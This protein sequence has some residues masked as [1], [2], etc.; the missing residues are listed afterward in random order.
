MISEVCITGF[1][2]FRSLNSKNINQVFYLKILEMNDSLNIHTEKKI[3]TIP[4]QIRKTEKKLVVADNSNEL[5]AEG[6]DEVYKYVRSIGVSINSKLIVLPSFHHYYYDSDELKKVKSVVVLKKLN[7]I[8]EIENFLD[9][10]LD[11]LPD[12]CNFIGSFINNNKVERYALRQGKTRSEKI[13]NSDRIELDIVSR[14]PFLNMVYSIM[15]ARTNSYMSERSV[16]MM[17]S[18]H[19][20]DVL[21]MTEKEGL[22][23]FHARKAVPRIQVIN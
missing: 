22:T 14:Y 12:K 18:D 16:T 6:G 1:V 10:H 3:R 17:L 4:F 7:R 19:G 20:F 2:D 23:Y 21:N 5:L 8:V 11:F 9:T 13:R 15:D